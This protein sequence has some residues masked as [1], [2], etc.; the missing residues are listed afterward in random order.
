MPEIEQRLFERDINAL[1]KYNEEGRLIGPV[2]NDIQS[3]LRQAQKDTL[4]RYLDKKAAAIAKLN[5]IKKSFTM[6]ATP[7]GKKTRLLTSKQQCLEISW[8]TGAYIKVLDA[9]YLKRNYY[10]FSHLT[11]TLFFGEYPDTGERIVVCIMDTEQYK[12]HVHIA[13]TETPSMQ[14]GNVMLRSGIG[15]PVVNA[16][17]RKL[18]EPES[19]PTFDRKKLFNHL[20]SKLIN[21]TKYLKQHTIASILANPQYFNGVGRWTHC[22]ISERLYSKYEIHP[23]ETAYK[24]LSDLSKLEK[25]ATLPTLLQ[26]EYNTFVTSAYDPA[27]FG[28]R[29]S[30]ANREFEIHMLKWYKQHN[31][32]GEE[33]LHFA[34]PCGFSSKLWVRFSI[35]PSA[36]SKKQIPSEECTLSYLNQTTVKENQKLWPKKAMLRWPCG[37]VWIRIPPQYLTPGGLKVGPYSWHSA[38]AQELLFKFGDPDINQAEKGPEFTQSQGGRNSKRRRKRRGKTNRLIRRMAVY[39]DQT[40]ISMNK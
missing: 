13:I 15:L 31:Y 40:L 10:P 19:I 5:Q 6:V 20:R 21:D 7:F 22:E 23:G 25:V 18:S 1:N 14:F 38:M 4:E 29:Q 3:C 30:K 39:Q 33:L 26:E 24:V 17:K 34:V 8:G 2:Y 35:P 9:T 27:N 28:P 16:K 11:N 37:E 36:L 32:Q 12:N